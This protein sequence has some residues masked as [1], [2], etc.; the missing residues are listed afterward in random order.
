M[1]MK[2]EGQTHRHPNHYPQSVDRTA[3]SSPCRPVCAA[4]ADGQHQLID[5]M[6][7]P[8]GPK[9]RRW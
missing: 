7:H 1:A 9:S 5:A 6:R 2:D 4:D 8:G 3:T